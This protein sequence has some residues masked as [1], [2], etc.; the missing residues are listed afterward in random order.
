MINLKVPCLHNFCV[1]IFIYLNI[2]NYNCRPFWEVKLLRNRRIVIFLILMIFISSLPTLSIAEAP[3]VKLEESPNLEKG[4]ETV[5]I[6]GYIGIGLLK[7]P[8]NNTT[9]QCWFEN[10]LT[11]PDVVTTTDENGYYVFPDLP[12]EGYILEDY[13]VAPIKDGY[14]PIG[15][16][17]IRIY[18]LGTLL[19]WRNF[20]LIKLTDT[21]DIPMYNPGIFP[22]ILFF[23][24]RIPFFRFLFNL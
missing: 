6:C 15:K 7:H 2:F 24:E 10:P 3:L 19:A 23:M 12:A 21:K 11:P 16:G 17:R 5:T 9:V 14:A 13:F 18:L 22:L 8:A 4:G 1:G 20:T